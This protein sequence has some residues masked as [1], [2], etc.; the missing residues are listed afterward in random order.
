[1]AEI[2]S[3]LVEFNSSRLKQGSSSVPV[4]VFLSL[5]AKS[6]TDQTAVPAV[7]NLGFSGLGW[8][9]TQP[10]ITCYLAIVDRPVGQIDAAF[11]GTAAVLHHRY[12]DI[13]SMSDSPPIY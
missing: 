7:L 11:G 6:F 4:P 13:F 5:F 3:L 10:I 2:T 9:I 12:T 8:Q 1:M